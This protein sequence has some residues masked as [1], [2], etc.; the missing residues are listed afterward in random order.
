MT[1]PKA[2]EGCHCCDEA[3]HHL[4]QRHGLTAERRQPQVPRKHAERLTAATPEV[5][6]KSE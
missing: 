6:K 4:N 5:G 2:D 1:E 3:Q